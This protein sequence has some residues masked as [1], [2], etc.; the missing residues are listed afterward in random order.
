MQVLF[1]A[2]VLSYKDLIR[3]YLRMFRPRRGQCE[4]TSQYRAAVFY[5]DEQ[6]KREAAEVLTEMGF[7]G[8][9]AARLLEPASVFYAA[10]EYHQKYYEKLYQGAFRK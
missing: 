1:D 5:E 2:N 3:D 10:E 8:D 9:S 7:D 6:Q 4:S